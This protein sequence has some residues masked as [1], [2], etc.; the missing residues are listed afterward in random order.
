MKPCGN[1]PDDRVTRAIELDSLADNIWY[2]T[3]LAFPQA[4]A[5]QSYRR[6]AETVF[7]GVEQAPNLRLHAESRKEN[8]RDHFAADMFGYANACQI[9]IVRAKRGHRNESV[10][11]SL[12]IE[13]IR[14][15]N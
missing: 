8:R 11:L 4:C 1:H 13:E 5:Y 10:V 14:I 7:F 3:E 2:R 15:G 12:P 9:E 6:A